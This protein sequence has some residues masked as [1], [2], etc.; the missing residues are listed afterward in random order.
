[1]VPSILQQIE[2]ASEQGKSWGTFALGAWTVSKVA[3]PR[4]DR[5]SWRSV[6]G[7]GWLLHTVAELPRWDSL[8]LLR[9]LL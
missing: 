9:A 2:Q 7:R 6:V 5:K 8:L 4:R 3:P 1:M